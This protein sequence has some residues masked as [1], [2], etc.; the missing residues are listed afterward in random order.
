MKLAAKKQLLN[1]LARVADGLGYDVARL[2]TDANPGEA[3]LAHLFSD[4]VD[5][6]RDVQ[7]LLARRVQDEETGAN[8]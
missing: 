1:K 7:M 3:H 2:S 5:A 6:L 8:R 4:A